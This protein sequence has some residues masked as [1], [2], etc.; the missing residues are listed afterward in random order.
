MLSDRSVTLLDMHA[1]R[2]VPEGLWVPVVTPF[3]SGDDVDLDSLERLAERLLGDG[4]DGLVALGTTGEPATLTSTEREQVVATCSAVSQ[5][6][7]RPLIV[8]AGT[9][10]TAGTIEEIRRHTE[11]VPV[12]AVLIVVPYYTRPTQQAIVEHFH[13]VADESPVPVVAYNVPYRTGSSLD[14]DALVAIGSHPNI[15]G[16]KQAVGALDAPTLDLLRR[17]PDG[18]NLLAG[19]DLFIAA[20]ILMGASGAISAAAHACTPVYVELVRAAMSGDAKRAADL[21]HRLTPVVSAGFSEPNPAVFKAALH[22]AGD[23]DCPALRRPM[24]AASDAARDRLIA[25]IADQR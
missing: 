11:R 6:H 19:D 24:T 8:G 17:L 23:I 5:R 12:A 25:A 10:S 22:H 21:T 14:A 3:T 9:N 15:V 16:L 20:T 13:I 18:F 4:V 2:F 7:G 1:A